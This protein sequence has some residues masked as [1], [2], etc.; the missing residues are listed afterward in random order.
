MAAET[1]FRRRVDEATTESPRLASQFG[2]SRRLLPLMELFPALPGIR[3]LHPEAEKGPESAHFRKVLGRDLLLSGDRFLGGCVE[4]PAGGEE[5]AKGVGGEVGVRVLAKIT[6]AVGGH[7]QL[8]Q[9]AAGGVDFERSV[10]G[11][12]GL[13]DAVDLPHQAFGEGRTVFRK[14]VTRHLEFAAD[15]KRRRHCRSESSNWEAEASVGC[16]SN[17]CKGREDRE[18]E[19]RRDR[20]MQRV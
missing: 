3:P 4:S 6:G 15:G 1:G 19:R 9:L 16:S 5:L 2:N 12:S 17:S 10:L 11:D 18:T 20:E 14:V 8:E 13:N 7:E